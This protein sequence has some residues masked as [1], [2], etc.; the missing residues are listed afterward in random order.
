MNQLPNGVKKV[1]EA[2]LAQHLSPQTIEWG[3]QGIS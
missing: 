1:I 3:V 2:Y